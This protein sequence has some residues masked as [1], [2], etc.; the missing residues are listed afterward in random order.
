LYLTNYR[1]SYFALLPILAY[2]VLRSVTGSVVAP[3]R[4]LV[5]ALTAVSVA[6]G[7]GAIA[8]ALQ[9][10]L[11]DVV[12]VAQNAPDYLKPPYDFTD[13][14]RDLFSS[15]VYIWSQYVY[16]Y[17]SGDFLTYLVGYGP[18]G[19]EGKF[20]LYAHNTFVGYIHDFGAIGLACLLLLLAT[21]AILSL[22]APEVE[23]RFALLSAHVGF[24]FLNM[25]TMPLWQIEG[26]IFYGLLCGV[27]WAAALNRAP[28]SRG[29]YRAEGGYA[30][31]YGR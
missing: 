21:N 22:R 16:E 19:W 30:A 1:T 14:E 5:G 23:L 28:M 15:R 27:T 6:I 8:I 20:H 3:Q 31:A 7:I 24:V 26:E 12:I 25:A 18:N 13:P 4:A 10:R 11:I 2:F 29:V 17:L 9:D